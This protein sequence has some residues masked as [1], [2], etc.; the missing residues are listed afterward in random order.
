M[1]L[2]VETRFEDGY[3]LVVP[4]GEIDLS[5]VDKFREVLNELIIQGHV[6][7]L[8]DLDDTDFIDSLGF[9]ALVGARRKAHTFRGSLGI[10]CSAD[11]ILRL[12]RVTGLDRVFTITESVAT[13]PPVPEA[14]ARRPAGLRDTTRA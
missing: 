3:A 5:T 1:D 2:E 6:H 9:G 8:V 13:Q 12:F 7:V 14:G 11:R 10:V 4:R